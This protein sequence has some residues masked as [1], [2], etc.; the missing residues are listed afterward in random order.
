MRCGLV[1]TTSRRID[2]FLDCDDDCYANLHLM[3]KIQAIK[4]FLLLSVDSWFL[5]EPHVFKWGTTAIVD[6]PWKQPTA[7]IAI[8]KTNNFQ[9]INNRINA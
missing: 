2:S 4:L 3:K 9:S 7:G 5:Y 8:T 1:P 6:A